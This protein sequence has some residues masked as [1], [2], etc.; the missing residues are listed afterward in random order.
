[1][2]EAHYHLWQGVAEGKQEADG[3]KAPSGGANASGTKAGLNPGAPA[4]VPAAAQPSPAQAAARGP[5]KHAVQQAAKQPSRKRSLDEAGLS[6]QPS[7][8]SRAM[9]EGSLQRNGDAAHTGSAAPA[10]SLGAGR[11]AA[12][13]QGHDDGASIAVADIEVNDPSASTAQAAPQCNSSSAP[14]AEPASAQPALANGAAPAGALRTMPSLAQGIQPASANG[15]AKVYRQ[16]SMASAEGELTDDM[17]ALE[18]SLQPQAAPDPAAASQRLKKWQEAQK[19]SQQVEVPK[20]DD[21]DAELEA[22]LDCFGQVSPEKPKQARVDVAAAIERRKKW[23]QVQA[24]AAQS[25]QAH[26]A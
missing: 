8:A 22:E 21:L 10:G 17:Q 6:E 7:P 19:A 15:A 25:A 26:A 1:M 18:D 23:Q 4:F 16:L 24:A 12:G 2:H 3:A 5:N 13:Q 11:P 14:A 20:Q 9:L